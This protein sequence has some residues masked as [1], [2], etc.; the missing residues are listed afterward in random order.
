MVD[1]DRL[2]SHLRDRLQLP[3]SY[4]AAIQALYQGDRYVLMDGDTR[5]R[6]IRPN[7]GVKQGCPLSPLLFGAWKI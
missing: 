7:A 2:W 3:D 1:R 6:E 4:L 5:T